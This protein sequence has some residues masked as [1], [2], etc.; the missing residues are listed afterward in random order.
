MNEKDSLL[1]ELDRAKEDQLA[2]D[3]GAP[4]HERLH[5]SM[6]SSAPASTREAGTS[7]SRAAIDFTRTAV[8][9]VTSKFEDEIKVP[10]KPY[11]FVVLHVQYGVDAV[12]SSISHSCFKINST[13]YVLTSNPVIVVFQ[14]FFICAY[15]SIGFSQNLTSQLEQQTKL[16]DFYREQVLELEEQIAKLREEGDITKDALKVQYNDLFLSVLYYLRE[17]QYFEHSTAH[18]STFHE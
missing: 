18:T 10:Y 7:I 13:L 8:H 9:E 2:Y 16:A 14:N 11:D 17:L 5:H 15:I 3:G 6:R 12:F 4:M 1:R